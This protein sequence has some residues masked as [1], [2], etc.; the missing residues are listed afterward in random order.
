MESLYRYIGERAGLLV[1]DPKGKV[2]FSKNADLPLVPAS[3][4][5]LVTAMAALDILGPDFRFKTEVYHTSENDLVLKGYADPLLISEALMDMA[6]KTSRSLAPQKTFRRL[7]VDDTFVDSNLVVPG[8]SETD[9]PYDAP[10]GAL[11]ANFNTV[12]FESSKSGFRSAESQTPMIPY[13]LDRIRKSGLG[14]GR[15]VFSHDTQEAALYAGHLFQYFLN[16]KGISFSLDVRRGRV[17]TVRHERVLS[18]LSPYPLRDVLAKLLEYSNNFIAIQVLLFL[19]AQSFGGLASLDKGIKAFQG[20]L[21]RQMGPGRVKIA[22]GSGLSR[23]NRIRAAD[24]CRCLDKLF[25]YRTLLKTEGRE[26]YKTGT[27]DGVRARAGYIQGNG[28]GFY[29]FAV[30]LNSPGKT[31]D[32]VM[33]ELLSGLP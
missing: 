24:L 6:D 23:E 14:A 33:K 22:E 31:V 25:P 30:L 5:K 9:N 29:R 28:G 15:I 32:P 4:L 8:R 11:C 27:L 19:G 17:D 13:A 1:L 3:T 20:Y 21:D 10:N 16:Q 7:V 2:V 12:T 18:Y 26:L